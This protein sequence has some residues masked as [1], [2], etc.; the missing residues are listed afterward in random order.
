MFIPN[1]L[2]C[3]AWVVTRA[4]RL[5]KVEIVKTA[6]RESTLIS[7]EGSYYHCGE[8]FGSVAE[9]VEARHARAE[10]RLVRM[11]ANVALLPRAE[12]GAA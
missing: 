5:K 2:P 12:G 8:V 4:L 3:D 11:R 1:K 7:S 9:A 10:D 6:Y